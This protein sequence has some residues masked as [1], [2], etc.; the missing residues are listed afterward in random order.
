MTKQ[1]RIALIALGVVVLGG[2]VTLSALK[3]RQPATEVRLEKVGRRDLT[4]IV[5]SSGQLEPKTK[6]DVSSDITGR[7]V[8]L[9][10]REGATVNRG[11]VV[12][13][14]D[15]AQYQAGVE[16]AQAGLASAQANVQQAQ[17]NL[18]QA[19]R[20]YVRLRD[21]HTQNAQLVTQESLEQ[22][23]TQQAVT[24]AN[25]VA[26]QRQVD[27]A[28]A[29]LHQA[30]DALEK[31]TIHAPMTGKITR[32][33]VEEGEVAV[34]GTFSRE[35]GLLM[36]I[37]DLSVIQVTVKV[38]ETDVVKIRMGDSAEVSIDAF[39]DT[40]FTGR[41][42]KIS[43]S[44]ITGETTT[45]STTT[46][47]QAVDYDVE[48]TLDHPPVGVRPDL[49]ATAR[50]VTDVRKHALAVPIIA[51]A[52]RPASDTIVDTAAAR[53]AAHPG[54]AQAQARP[55]A[56][57]SS[58]AGAAK[59]V[60]GVFVEDTTTQLVHFRPVKVGITGDEYFEVLDGLTEGQTIV[61]GP[62]QAVRDMHNNARV[63]PMPKAAGSTGAMPAATP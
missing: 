6:V 33:A 45:T 14:I 46:Q 24:A 16:Q 48:V 60:E 28:S 5:T 59:E 31:T 53:R 42:T 61:S 39:P 49:S 17:A 47:D 23:Q 15:P 58:R 25:L 36:T 18:D 54:G 12:V 2:F 34:P 62:Y 22:A 19:Q 10:Y 41:V 55:T 26:A 30:Q 8:A 35:T 57:T 40:V 51:L 9:P 4:S 43:N 21:L 37:S 3:R 20:A 63:K 11:D 44:S 32:L 50:I 13:R 56:D 27:Q 1:K 29:T 38:D 52:V 7:I